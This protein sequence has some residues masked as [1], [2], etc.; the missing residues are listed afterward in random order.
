MNIERKIKSFVQAA[1]GSTAALTSGARR[2][3]DADMG[4]ALGINTKSYEQTPGKIINNP[5]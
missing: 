4:R 3:L 5:R 2:V 1:A